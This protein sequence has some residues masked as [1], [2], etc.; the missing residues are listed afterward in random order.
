MKNKDSVLNAFLRQTGINPDAYDQTEEYE[1]EMEQ[2]RRKEDMLAQ[3]KVLSGLKQQETSIQNNAS[4]DIPRK[5]KPENI[6]QTTEEHEHFKKY[7][8]SLEQNRWK[9]IGG[10]YEF[11]EMNDI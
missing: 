2:K 5:S 7:D 9:I 6:Q 10:E 8:H 3:A 1:I 11:I 4:L